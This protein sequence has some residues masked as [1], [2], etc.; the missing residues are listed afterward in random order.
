M[1]G[2]SG[3]DQPQLRLLPSE[4]GELDQT[5]SSVVDH[6]EEQEMERGTL[7]ERRERL[8]RR[9]RARVGVAA[10]FAL[11]SVVAWNVHE[12][13]RPIPDLELDG[14]ETQLRLQAALVADEIDEF[15]QIHGRLPTSLAEVDVHGQM[16]LY[17]AVDDGY[18]LAV[19]GRDT[20]IEYVSE[21]DP[22]ALLED[23]NGGVGSG[24]S[25]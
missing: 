7:A 21:E 1:S 3:P 16:F 23:W 24:G 14:D 15:H 9:R 20:T 22:A 12:W 13:N 25:R 11:A 5:I 18:Y 4:R 19:R 17:T 8:R 10:V 2:T 6:V